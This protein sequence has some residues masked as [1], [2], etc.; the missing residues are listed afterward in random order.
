MLDCFI[1]FLV[2]SGIDLLAWQ[3]RTG[4]IE[5][6]ELKN[7]RLKRF[8]KIQYLLETT[9]RRIEVFPFRTYLID[10]IHKKA[11]KMTTELVC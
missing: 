4:L 6:I 3:K 10:T 8:L 5:R 2:S 1:F 7:K 11:S 9:N